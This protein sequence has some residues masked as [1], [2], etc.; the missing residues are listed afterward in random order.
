MDEQSGT[1]TLYRNVK[2]IDDTNG[3]TK[4]YYKTPNDY[5]KIPFTGGG[6]DENTGHISILRRADCWIKGGL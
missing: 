3:Y 5:P 6:A 2:I 1:Y 4:L